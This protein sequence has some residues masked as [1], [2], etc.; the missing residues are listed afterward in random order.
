MSFRITATV[1][2]SGVAAS[3]T[4]GEFV[5]F[6]TMMGEEFALPLTTVGWLSSAITLVAGL[7]CLPLGVW[8]DRRR[9]RGMFVAALVALGMTGLGAVVVQGVAQ[10]FL[11]RLVQAAGYAVVVVAGPG[12]LAR[13]LQGRAR[14]AALASWGLCIPAGLA[15]AAVLGAIVGAAGWRANATAVGALALV[16]AALA[17]ALP[18]DRY[19][20]QE[21]D[22]RTGTV[23][24]Q[25][26][27]AL[28][29]AGFAMIAL[30]GVSVVTFLPAYLAAGPGWSASRASLAAG[31][32]SGVSV[33]GSLAAGGALRAR[34]R[35]GRLIA[36]ALLMAPL[37]AGV[38]LTP[39]VAATVY[40]GAVLGINGLAVS[41]VFAALPLVAGG[42]LS[43]GAGAVTQAGSLGTLLG[44]PLYAWVVEAGGWGAAIAVT[45]VLSCGGVGCAM[46]A[47]RGGSRRGA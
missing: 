15:L 16:A 3:A 25:W 26:A 27:V 38:F 5:P 18:R 21:E 4:L 45:A 20:R 13:L 44:P 46:A 1:L 8:M 47:L 35:P 32:V 34:V 29:A 30:V 11:L 22:G 37:S 33:L 39:S 17:G 31:L 6:L 43:L 40:A 41:A 19:H 10:L 14:R 28:L 24:K 2:A 12:L 42:R 23:N 7:G 9:L 36:A